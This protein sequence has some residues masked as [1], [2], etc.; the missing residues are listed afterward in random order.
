MVNYFAFHHGGTD[1]FLIRPNLNFLQFALIKVYNA[2]YFTMT[3][4]LATSF[5][6]FDSSIAK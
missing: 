6:N 5:G 1:F 3:K 2:V 4:S